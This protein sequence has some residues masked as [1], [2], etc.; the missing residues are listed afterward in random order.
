M[1]GYQIGQKAEF[2]AQT[3]IVFMTNGIFLQRIIHDTGF[4]NEY[5]FVVLDEVHERDIDT[6]FILTAIKRIIRQFP[7][8]R[9]ILMSA[10]IDNELFRY[11]FASDHIDKFMEED[12]F[13]KKIIELEEYEKAKDDDDSSDEGFTMK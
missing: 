11:Y 7:K 9:I 2:N 5:P 4:L 10:T 6:D 1:V 13:Y 3:R 8:V 12:N